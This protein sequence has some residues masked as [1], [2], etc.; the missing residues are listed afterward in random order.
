MKQMIETD[1]PPIVIYN[2]AKYILA[3][4]HPP[5]LERAKGWL[6]KIFWRYRTRL[7]R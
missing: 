5:F 6:L 3:A 7:S 1:A 2:E 4:W